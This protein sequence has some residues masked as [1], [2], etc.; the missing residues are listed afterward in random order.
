MNNKNHIFESESTL[1]I[2]AEIESNP[3]ITQRHLSQKL[4]ISLGKINFLINS[5]IDKGVVEVENFKNSKHKLA[6]MYML[7]PKGI[8]TKLN[9]MQ[10]FLVWK[11]QEYER[12]KREIE[13]LKKESSIRR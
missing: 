6:Y 10:K 7:T 8:K 11:K 12:L 13:T 2:L 9:L 4:E 3:K 5:L 1:Q